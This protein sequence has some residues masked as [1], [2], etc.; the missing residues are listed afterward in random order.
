MS[1]SNPT[2]VHSALSSEQELS[3]S[4]AA[5]ESSLLNKD[6]KESKKPTLSAL[7]GSC[8]CG[9]DVEG[10]KETR[11]DL[12]RRIKE[13]SSP[14]VSTDEDDAAVPAVLSSLYSCAALDLGDDDDDDPVPAS[15]LNDPSRTICVITTA[16]MPWR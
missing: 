8:A 15:M 2:D 10:M 12:I 16:A 5:A 6:K 4:A 11:D 1:S 13:A 7:S 3:V 9:V 14:K